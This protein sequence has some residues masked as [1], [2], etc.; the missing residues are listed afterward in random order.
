MLNPIK[1]EIDPTLRKYLGAELLTFTQYTL[2]QNIQRFQSGIF[3]VISDLDRSE[4]WKSCWSSCPWF[5]NS[6]SSIGPFGYVLNRIPRNVLSISADCACIN[7]GVTLGSN[8]VYTY[9]SEPRAPSNV[10]A[11]HLPWSRGHHI[12]IKYSQEACCER[13]IA[14][15]APRVAL[16]FWRFSVGRKL[17]NPWQRKVRILCIYHLNRDISS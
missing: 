16:N 6:I 13:E 7:L 3:S 9:P 14:A 5:S 1:T 15:Q 2:M 17:A 4:K 11:S 12:G 10:S 8:C